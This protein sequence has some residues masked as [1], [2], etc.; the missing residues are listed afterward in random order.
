MHFRSTP[1]TSITLLGRDEGASELWS[2]PYTWPVP[3]NVRI[4]QQGTTPDYVHTFA[5]LG[6]AIASIPDTSGG[7]QYV[8]WVMP[9]YYQTG[10]IYMK[11]YVSIRGLAREA[12]TLSVI[13]NVLGANTRRS[14][15]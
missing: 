12:V 4:V 5:D 14:R 8:V 1:R 3:S 11:P 13:G 15:T 2:T 10:T 6:Q 9:G 7:A